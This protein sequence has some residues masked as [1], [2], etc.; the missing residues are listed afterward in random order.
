MLKKPCSWK[1]PNPE[2][3]VFRIYFHC[4]YNVKKSREMIQKGSK[5]EAK[6]LLNPGHDHPG[7][8]REGVQ[9]IDQKV[10]KWIPK[11]SQHGAQMGAI[12]HEKKTLKTESIPRWVPGSPWEPSGP[13]WEPLWSISVYVFVFSHVFF[14]IFLLNMCVSPRVFHIWP[15]LF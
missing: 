1:S 9:K 11:G 6:W 8:L 5:M 12:I 4:F 14:Y 7:L 2:K 10:T 3:C 15:C 13:L